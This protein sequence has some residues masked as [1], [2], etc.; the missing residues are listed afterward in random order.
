MKFPKF[1]LAIFSIFFLV[2]TGCEKDKVSGPHPDAVI[3]PGT[4]EYYFQLAQEVTSPRE[5]ISALNKG[6][7]V[8]KN[9]RDTLLPLLL[10]YKIKNHNKLKE[11]DSSLYFVDNLI[12]ISQ[13]QKDTSS[14]A[15]GFYRKSRI[16]E[17]LKNQEEV[18]G[19]NFEARRLFLA[20]KDSSQAGRRTLEMAIAQNRLGDFTGS[21]ETATEALKLLDKKIDS[22]YLSSAYNEIAMVYRMQKFYG[23][24][25]S[26]YKNALRFSSSTADS[27]SILNNLAVVFKDKK[28]Y[29]DAILIWEDIIEKTDSDIK[30][31]R[32]LDNLTYTKWLQ[33]PSFAAEKD[34][35]VALH[36][37]N[38]IP[39]REGL[40]GSF[41]HL[42]QFYE[43][44]DVELSTRYSEKL[45][46][47]AQELQNTDAEF[48][49]LKRLIPTSA[50]PQ[51]RIYSERYMQL[52]DSV[53]EAALK[54]KNTFAKI[55]FD[56]E[57][58]QQ[59][60]VG[61]EAQNTMQAMETRQLRTRSWIGVLAGTLVILGLFFLSYY[62]RQR[63]KKHEIREVHKT[64]S[65]I[66][67]VIHDEL[68]NDI[69]NIMSSLEP[70]AP[71]PV[72][73]KLEKI[74]LRTRDISRENREIDTGEDYVDYLK[75]ILSNNT[76]EDSKL[77][78]S[79]EN[80][81]NWDKLKEE[82]KIVIYRVLQELMINMKKHSGA[83][84]VAIS[85]VVKNKTLSIRYS[86][87]GCG[88]IWNP[89]KK[90]SGIQNVENRISSLNGK[91]TFESEKGN[92]FKIDMQIPV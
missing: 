56:K 87:N 51:T 75:A 73:D 21:Q 52:I 23:D 76:P 69:F 17:Y 58:K 66:S 91:I 88:T 59:E 64:E 33:D 53:Q 68:A 43:N 84:L 10:D 39:D 4:G 29:P 1:S 57:H 49:A 30:K 38:E 25:A 15:K 92:G 8:I 78:V 9:R 40:L 34:L 74:Y 6:L 5:K 22:V 18:Y 65:R 86:D 42:S 71:V 37:R 61:L 89:S 82:K 67:K 20:I 11:Y 80:S 62:F 12:N 26:E 32:Y 14:L 45:L 83:K 63:Q 70:V 41:D 54:A 60:I 55:R 16:N 2:L 46:T 13:F 81:V 90:G 47:M 36:M 35:L 19:Y 72:I 3:Q 27:L 48:I 7:L 31:A 79:G 85:F 24:A 77:I 50:L 28:N 44:T